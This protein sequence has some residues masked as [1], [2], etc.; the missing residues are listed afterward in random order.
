MSIVGKKSKQTSQSTTQQTVDPQSRAGLDFLLSEAKGLKDAPLVPGLSD[1]TLK[2]VGAVGADRFGLDP[3]SLDTLRGAAAGDFA[4]SPGEFRAADRG[5]LETALGFAGEEAERQV[6]DLFTAGGR[7]GSPAQSK[8]VAQGV[9][10]AIAPLLVQFEQNELARR[11]AFDIGEAN[12]I[13]AN[14]VQ[15]IS[16]SLGLQSIVAQQDRAALQDE[17]A[18][19]EASGIIDAQARAKLEEPFRRLGLIS[20][21]I[22]GAASLGDKTL[23]QEGSGTSSSFGFSADIIKPP[24]G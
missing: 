10:E 3:T 15:Q 16:A 4:R 22:L 5:S 23:E 11:D 20:Q 21:S 19:L 17:F 13:D 7:T 12:R 8:A 6:S 14:T 9:T 1:L 24:G 18:R 2:N